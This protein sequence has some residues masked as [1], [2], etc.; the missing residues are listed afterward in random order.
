MK[1]Y[2]ALEGIS[3]KEANAKFEKATMLE[4]KEAL[5]ATIIKKICPIG[6]RV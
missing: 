4:F 1:I 2:C 3:H 5:A 6:E